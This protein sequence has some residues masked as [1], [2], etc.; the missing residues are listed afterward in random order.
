MSFLKRLPWLPPCLFQTHS[1]I[2][3]IGAPGLGP[4][5][6]PYTGLRKSALKVLTRILRARCESL[7]R[8]LSA[9]LAVVALQH[10]QDCGFEIGQCAEAVVSG[11]ETGVSAG[12]RLRRRIQR[13]LYIA[14]RP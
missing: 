1:G 3:G 4:A 6:S 14:G 7:Y 12:D 13:K 11:I 5:D 10:A 2:R 8:Q 9:G